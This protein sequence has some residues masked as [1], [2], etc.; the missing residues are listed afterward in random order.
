MTLP[1]GNY[2]KQRIMPIRMVIEHRRGQT[3]QDRLNADVLGRI[4]EYHWPTCTHSL[5]VLDV[6]R[7]I[8]TAFGIGDEDL[9]ILSQ[10]AR[11]HDVGKIAVPQYILSKTGPLDDEELAIVREHPRNGFNLLEGLVDEAVRSLVVSHHEFG[12]DPYPRNA[13]SEES[14]SYTGPERRTPQ[15]TFLSQIVAA[16]DMYT[17]LTERRSYREPMDPSNARSV[18]ERTFRGDPAIIDAITNL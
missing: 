8:G 1:D 16:A 4:R 11:L 12:R 7:H 18:L 6:S 3:Y 14:L 17:A 15:D 13:Y 2:E 9:K 10:G 5:S